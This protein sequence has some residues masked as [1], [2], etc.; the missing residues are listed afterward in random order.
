MDKKLL[1]EVGNRIKAQRIKSGMTIQQVADKLG[2]ARIT[3]AKQESGTENLSLDTLSRIAS[4][5][6]CSVEVIL[7]PKSG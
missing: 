5:L 7:K 1:K 6:S 3:Y 4:A 2:V